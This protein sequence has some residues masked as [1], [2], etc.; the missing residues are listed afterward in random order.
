MTAEALLAALRSATANGD[1]KAAW[2][3]RLLCRDVAPGRT[4]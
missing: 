3:L 2:M 1:A 4:H